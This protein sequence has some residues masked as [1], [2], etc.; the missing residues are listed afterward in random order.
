MW[1]AWPI[2][3][4]NTVAQ[5]PWV[6]VIPPLSP[7][8]VFVDVSPAALV[9]TAAVSGPLAKSRTAAP[10]AP[11]RIVLRRRPMTLI[12][13]GDLNLELSASAEHALEVGL[14]AELACASLLR[15]V[16]P[17]SFRRTEID[18]NALGRQQNRKSSPEAQ[19]LCGRIHRC[20]RA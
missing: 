6:K 8:Q 3:S 18:A 2:W 14:L 16:C 12:S 5:N 4:A 13:F 7:A 17:C 10:D 15:L 9:S 20:E 11:N 1:R 19:T